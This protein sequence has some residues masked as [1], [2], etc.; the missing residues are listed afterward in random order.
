M[1]PINRVSF[2]LY[3]RLVKALSRKCLY[4]PYI[5]RNYIPGEVALSSHSDY[6]LREVNFVEINGSL[7]CTLILQ[8]MNMWKATNNITKILQKRNC[9]VI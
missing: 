6:F 5:R 8:N 2:D 1:I 9:K 7:A 3:V 4:L